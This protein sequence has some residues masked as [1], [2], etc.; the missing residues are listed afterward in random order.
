MYSQCIISFSPRVDR[1]VQ[2]VWKV[3]DD[4]KGVLIHRKGGKP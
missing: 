4:G 3:M 2:T 1:T